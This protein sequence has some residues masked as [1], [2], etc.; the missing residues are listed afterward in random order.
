LLVLLN[1]YWTAADPPAMRQA[2]IEDWLEDLIEFGPAVV[3]ESLREWR[4]MPVNRRP[5]PGEIRKLC[6]ESQTMRQERQKP[7][8]SNLD[9]YARSVGWASEDERM[10]AI[11]RD[12]RERK[13]RYE[14]ARLVREQ[15]GVSPAT[16]HAAA[17]L[18]VAARE[19]TADELRAGRIALG[20]ERPDETTAAGAA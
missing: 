15:A 1:H 7:G 11:D 5:V 10:A 18:G 14:R 6:I 4:R 17:A 20:L 16:A 12:K 9:E 8:P 13:A 19:Y 2:Q 3:A